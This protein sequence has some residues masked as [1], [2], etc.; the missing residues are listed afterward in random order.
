MPKVK[1]LVN[2]FVI[3]ISK[4]MIYNYYEV[5]L[6]FESDYVYFD[7]QADSINLFI[8]VGEERPTIKEPILNFILLTM[9]QFLISQ[10]K[11][12]LKLL[13]II[14]YNCQKNIVLEM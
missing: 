10:K 13:K 8:N 12:F 2:E 3:T 1:I 6:P 7:W 4:D 11:I 5:T 14:K 9:I